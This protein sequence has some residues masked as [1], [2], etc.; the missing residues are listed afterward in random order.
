MVR[1]SKVR[2]NKDKVQRRKAR[3]SKVQINKVQRSKARISKVRMVKNRGRHS[4]QIPN[5]PQKPKTRSSPR[6]NS[7]MPQHQVVRVRR[8]KLAPPHPVE[9]ERE[10]NRPQESLRMRISPRPLAHPPPGPTRREQLRPDQHPREQV[11]QQ[12]PPEQHPTVER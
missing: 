2:I 9:Q 1:T 3:T 6:T 10:V 11:L 12:R 5:R 7:R 4:L 8:A